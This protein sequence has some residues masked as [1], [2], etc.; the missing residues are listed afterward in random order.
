V[1][2]PLYTFSDSG[3]QFAVAE[4]KEYCKGHHITPL[5]SSA[6]FPKSDGLAQSTVKWAKYLLLKSDSYM[7]CMRCRIY[8]R[9][10][11]RCCPL[12]K[13]SKVGLGPICLPWIRFSI[14]FRLIQKRG[15]NVLRL[16]IEYV[17]TMQIQ[18]VGMILGQSTKSETADDC[19]ILIKMGAEILSCA[20]IFF[21][22]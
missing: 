14:Q 12:K 17:S 11:T 7:D 22:S 21:Y 18:N 20:I 2:F 6:C 1:G 3:P 8:R 5:V 16:E 19:I 13:N 4:F 15:E 9:Q 10:G